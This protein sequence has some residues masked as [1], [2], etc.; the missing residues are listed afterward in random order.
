MKITIHADGACSGNPGPGGWGATVLVDTGSSRQTTLLQGG[1]AMTTNNI[2]ELTAARAALEHIQKT[3]GEGLKGAQITLRLDSEYVLKGMRDWLP[4]W[5]R[6]GWRTGKG[7]EVKNKE[8][9]MAID[10][11]EQKL[12]VLVKISFVHVRGHSGDPENDRVDAIAVE[13][14]DPSR[15]RTGAWSAAPRLLADP[16][17]TPDGP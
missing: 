13:A 1:S 16:D 14:R 15:D 2:M 10:A 9:W 5:K 7:Q 11:V 4:G 17:N 6:K 3:F 12:K 8:I